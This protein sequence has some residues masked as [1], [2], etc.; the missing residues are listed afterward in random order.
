MNVH[1]IL[2]EPSHP[3]NVGS[4]ARAIKAM[5][6]KSLRLVNPCDHFSTESKKLAYGAHDILHA[7]TVFP[8][9]SEAISDIDFTIATTAKK[10]TLWHDY[11][12]P[13]ACVDLIRSKGTVFE[14]IGIVFGRE[15][16]GLLT[17]EM[18]LC[19][20][21]SLIP[22]ANPYPSINL[23]QSVMIYAHIFSVYSIPQKNDIPLSVDL[24]EQRILKSKAMVLLEEIEVT[25]NP[26]LYRRMTERLMQINEDDIHLFLSFHRYLKRK[27]KNIP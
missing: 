20:L 9:L 16:S 4:A 12:T 23:A 5:G 21:R 10:R 17:E 14:T 27:L 1:F 24:N 13:E 19:D 25:K 7:A 26:N 2:T 22:I 3:G 18:A 15:E 8:S 6:F 11:F